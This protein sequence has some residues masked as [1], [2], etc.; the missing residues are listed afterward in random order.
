MYSTCIRIRRSRDSLFLKRSLV[1]SCRSLSTWARSS[2]EP[3][4]GSNSHTC[5]PRK[6]LADRSQGPPPSPIF[7]F[8]MIEPPLARM[9]DA[10][11]LVLRIKLSQAADGVPSFFLK[12]TEVLPLS[13]KEYSQSNVPNILHLRREFSR[14]CTKL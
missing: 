4:S 3:A 2:G 6:L 9:S 13:R 11:S 5:L 1:N 14:P 8:H 12:P 7:N 10:L